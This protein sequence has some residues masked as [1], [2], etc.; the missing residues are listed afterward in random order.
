MIFHVGVYT[1]SSDL[2][3][4]DWAEV[5]R[6]ER[7]FSFPFATVLAPV[8][9]SQDITVGL[10]YT[11]DNIEL[12][13]GGTLRTY[14]NDVSST[15]LLP[16]EFGPLAGQPAATYSDNTLVGLGLTIKYNY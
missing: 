6:S 3:T 12:G 1:S 7:A 15:Q 13:L 8:D 16:E 10:R 5:A 4:A 9:G 11:I 14:T 2:Q